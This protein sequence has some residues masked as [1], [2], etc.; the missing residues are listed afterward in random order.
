MDAPAVPPPATAAVSTTPGLTCHVL[1]GLFG[2]N[3]YTV[4]IKIY[5]KPLFELTAS[6]MKEISDLLLSAHVL[7]KAAKPGE[8]GQWDDDV[9]DLVAER[10]T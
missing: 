9:P 1:A 7:V 8:R 4:Y 2:R 5:G 3:S 10:N 6:S